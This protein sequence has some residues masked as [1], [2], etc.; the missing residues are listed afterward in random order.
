MIKLQGKG[1]HVH[2]TRPYVLLIFIWDKD[3]RVYLMKP[4]K[5]STVILHPA[6]LPTLSGT[7]RP[8]FYDPCPLC[9]HSPEMM[10]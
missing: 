5:Y 3:A 10:V 2:R 6:M 1:N 4:R 8:L 7:A 9:M